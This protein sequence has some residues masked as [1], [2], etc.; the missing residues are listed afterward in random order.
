[1]S[2][3]RVAAAA[4]RSSTGAVSVPPAA[5][6]A[7]ESAM[8]AERAVIQEACA[9]LRDH[10]PTKALDALRR[11]RADFKEPRFADVR[12]DLRH[13]AMDMREAQLHP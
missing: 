8:V 11:H 4:L 2:S 9:A 1:M 3:T 6:S 13:Q 12:D 7:A 10:D 5:A